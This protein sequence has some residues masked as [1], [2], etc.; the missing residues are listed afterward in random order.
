M[1]IALAK[2]LKAFSQ[3]IYYLDNIYY[4]N[5]FQYC[6]LYFGNN[7]Y[8]GCRKSLSTYCF[9]TK[10]P[11]FCVKIYQ[12]IDPKVTKTPPYLLHLTRYKEVLK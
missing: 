1:L 10:I 5:K 11:L 6:F 7:S 9:A 3:Y 12:R 8:I 4:V 2:L